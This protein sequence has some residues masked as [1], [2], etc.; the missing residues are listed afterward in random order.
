MALSASLFDY[1][2]EMQSEAP[3]AVQIFPMSERPARWWAWWAFGP[4]AAAA[5]VVIGWWWGGGSDRRSRSEP[6]SAVAEN[7]D[8][9]AR[10][11][12]VEN[13]QW[14][15]A[16][17]PV[18]EELRR[19]Q[20]LQ[21]KSGFAEV[22]FDSGATVTL[23]GP[24]ALDLSSEWEAVL[25]E[26]TLKAEVP[27]EAVGFRVSNPEVEVVDLGTAF[28]MVAEGSGATEVFVLQGTIEAHGRGTAQPV[29]LRET[30]ARRF[31]GA[32]SGDV[33]DLPQKLRRLGK[34]VA[35][36]R[37]ERPV[38]YVHWSFNGDRQ[39]AA[40][41][42]VGLPWP[43]P[44]AV[45]QGAGPRPEASSMA[46]RFAQALRCDGTF[47]LQAPRPAANQAVLHTAAFWVKLAPEESLS[48]AGAMLSWPGPLLTAPRVEVAWNRNPAQGPVGALRTELGRGFIIGTTPLRD[49]RWHH[50]AVVLRE[51]RKPGRLQVIQYVDGKLENAAF[52]RGLGRRPEATA[53]NAATE[54]RIGHGIK[55]DSAGFQGGLDELY[56]TDQALSPQEIKS[57]IQRNRLGP[58]Q[59]LY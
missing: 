51:R 9:V 48:E 25:K 7:D 34:R 29:V 15:G 37:V 40:P 54:V 49:G 59:P 1:A 55:D 8:V 46:G 43:S 11:S 22:A 4:L 50:V 33:R 3:D 10:L 27:P 32:A 13:C 53:A 52:R 47:F 23:E 19:G 56:L 20:H 42:V 35:L 24:A 45:W 18:G 44:E 17:L 12:G 58:E 36:Q 31:A 30:Q 5:M 28:S 39:E 57:L 41:E 38:G 6:A 2:A 21:L 16:D 26:G 14:I